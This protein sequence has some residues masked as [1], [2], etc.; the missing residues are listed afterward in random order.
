M[1]L[2]ILGINK[3]TAIQKLDSLEKMLG[4]DKITTLPTESTKSSFPS[5]NDDLERFKRGLK[6]FN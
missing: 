4:K 3:E 5:Q 2:S 6:S 1:I